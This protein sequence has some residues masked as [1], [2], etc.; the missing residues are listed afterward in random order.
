MDVFLQNYLGIKICQVQLYAYFLVFPKLQGLN[1]VFHGESTV[2]I[3]KLYNRKLFMC[4]LIQE[5]ERLR[6]QRFF[7]KNNY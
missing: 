2:S 3:L 6:M 5:M 4:F 7:D 1:E